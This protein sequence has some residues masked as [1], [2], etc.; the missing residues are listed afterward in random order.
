MK[1]M[2]LFLLLLMGVTACKKDADAAPDGVLIRVRNASPYAFESVYVNTSGGENTYGQVAA[3][4]SSD[5]KLFANAYSYAYIKVSANGQEVVW[6]PIDYV[7]EKPLEPGRY[8][9]V[10][11]IDDLANRRISLQLEK[12]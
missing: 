4:Q 1:N 2:L 5:Y 7:G 11:G 8:T 12:H 10:L 6:Q 9:Y 3:G